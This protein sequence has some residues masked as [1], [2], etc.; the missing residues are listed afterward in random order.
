MQLMATVI[1]HG[2][3]QDGFL[4]ERWLQCVSMGMTL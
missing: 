2:F 1:M 3:A 4:V